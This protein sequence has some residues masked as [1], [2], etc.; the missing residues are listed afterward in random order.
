VAA[1]LKIV[2]DFLAFLQ[3][4]LLRVL[5]VYIS[6]YQGSRFDYNR[7]SDFQGF[8]IAVLMFVAS[9]IQTVCLNQACKIPLLS[10]C[11]LPIPCLVLSTMLRDW[12]RNK[13][14]VRSTF[15]TLC[16]MRVRAGLVSVIYKK[17]LVLSNDERSRATGDI[18]N[19]MSVDAMRLQDLC[20]YGLIALSGP[21][22][23]CFF[24]LNWS[25]Y[26]MLVIRSSSPSYL[27]TI[28]LAGLLL[29]EWL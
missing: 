24:D 18:V 11:V 5:L 23:V 10:H 27:C 21:L 15:L 28:F 6:A 29:L 3:P 22:Q 9:I 26:L 14:M 2:Q 20:T 19:L 8:A 13:S 12:V 4:Q 17:A 1:G 25:P 7:P 16:R